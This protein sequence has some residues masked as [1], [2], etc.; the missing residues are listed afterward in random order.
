ML[1]PPGGGEDAVTVH[2]RSSAQALVGRTHLFLKAALPGLVLTLEPC[3][4]P[5]TRT[6]DSVRPTPGPPQAEGVPNDSGEPSVP[7]PSAAGRVWGG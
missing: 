4:P 7:S 1:T 5:S 6:S 2:L 3:S